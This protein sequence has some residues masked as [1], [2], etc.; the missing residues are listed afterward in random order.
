V[1][2]KVAPPLNVFADLGFHLVPSA[3]MLI[4]LLFFSPPSKI[5]A[6]PAAGVSTGIAVAYWFWVEECFRNNGFYPYPIFDVAGFNGRV[7][8]F[9]MSAVIM[10]SGMVGL[11]VLHG[12]ING[13]EEESVKKNQ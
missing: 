7:G 2:P 6:L 1:L 8:L 9:V 12:V 5:S 10:A 4:D 13:T 11:R 3:V